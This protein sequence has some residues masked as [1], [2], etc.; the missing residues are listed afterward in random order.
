[1]PEEVAAVPTPPTGSDAAKEP[2][3]EPRK[4]PSIGLAGDEHV[5]AAALVTLEQNAQIRHLDQWEHIDALRALVLTNSARIQRQEVAMEGQ[6]AEVNGLAAQVQGLRADLQANYSDTRQH[7]QKSAD[8]ALRQHEEL[9]KL[10]G[11]K[12][13]EL[14]HHEKQLASVEE[15]AEEA[16]QVA[17]VAQ[18]VATKAQEVATEAK[19]EIT[20]TNVVVA[21]HDAILT[22]REKRLAAAGGFG[23]ISIGALIW[24]LVEHAPAIWKFLH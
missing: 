19:G 8:L 15:I 23:G 5:M 12:G 7:R 18:D 3:R 4:V 10:I 22:P 17:D 24:A 9:R 2:R 14:A 21:R 13:A 11:D 16:Q 1:M 20:K 6:R